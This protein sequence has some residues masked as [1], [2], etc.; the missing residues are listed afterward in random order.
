M[1]KC[2]CARTGAVNAGVRSHRAHPGLQG[3]YLYS[4]GIYSVLT[5][6][7]PVGLVAPEAIPAEVARA[8]Q[9]TA[10]AQYQETS[11]FLKK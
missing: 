10:W 7:S 8:L 3:S 11:A 1:R 4:C 5:G 9:E 6:R 2:S